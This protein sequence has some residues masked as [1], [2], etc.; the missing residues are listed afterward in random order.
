MQNRGA[1]HTSHTF[2]RPKA[3]GFPWLAFEIREG[4]E[5]KVFLGLSPAGEP[6]E[7]SSRRPPLTLAEIRA[8]GYG[9][10]RWK[11]LH[12]PFDELRSAGA[13]AQARA[14]G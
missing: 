13:R 1:E 2:D 5:S 7:P 4:A 8:L 12:V 6:L 3:R 10:E 11:V 14:R 9:S